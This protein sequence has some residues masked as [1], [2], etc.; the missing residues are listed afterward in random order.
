MSVKSLVASM[1]IYLFPVYSCV[2][3]QP[4]AVYGSFSMVIEKH[5]NFVLSKSFID[6]GKLH[7]AAPSIYAK[8]IFLKIS[9]GQPKKGDT[10]YINVAF[11]RYF[12][13]SY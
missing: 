6:L 2:F 4:S 7:G 1:C 13:K 11:C 8:S 9:F 5:R 10:F 3:L 12:I